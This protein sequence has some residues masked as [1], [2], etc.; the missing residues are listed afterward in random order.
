MKP[1]A[2]HERIRSEIE[3]HI[4]SGRWA[5]GD[6]VPGEV[7]LM[8]QYGCARMTVNKALSTLATAGLIE[9]RRRAGSFVARP[10]VQSMILDVPDL[11]SEV[12]G[13]GQAYAF[14]LL[15]REVRKARAGL[16]GPLGTVG[17]LLELEGI[18]FANG[19]PL[20]FERRQVALAPVP[21]ISDVDFSSEAPGGWLLRHIPWTEAETTI[22][23]ANASDVEGDIL[24]LSAGTACLC[25]ERY[26]WRGTTPITHVK[27]LFPGQAYQL[28]ARFGPRGAG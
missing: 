5:P 15:R 10:R 3:A 7:E 27:Q 16:D 20:A 8:A 19:V 6:R 24:G 1:A 21:E 12:V 9:R 11:A 17:E 18:H 2:L 26:T 23:A 13:R 14:R 25:V 28:S 4:L 22:T